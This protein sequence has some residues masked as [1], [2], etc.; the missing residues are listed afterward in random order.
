[1]FRWLRRK[2][3]WHN[4]NQ[5]HNWIKILQQNKSFVFIER[6]FLSLYTFWIEKQNSIDDKHLKTL[7]QID[8]E[9]IKNER[10]LFKTW[11]ETLNQMREH[12]MK[13]KTKNSFV[14][15]LNQMRF[16]KSIIISASS[17]SFCS[18]SQSAYESS[19][20]SSSSFSSS[21][22]AAYSLSFSSY[23]YLYLYFSSS[24]SH[25]QFLSK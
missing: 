1:M 7:K 23:F 15:V 8:R 3:L 10:Q 9:E 22:S 4:H 16:N 25:Q 20:S 21:S 24:L 2:T 19:Y 5:M 17:S 13:M 12:E 14:N 11:F 18:W 6:F